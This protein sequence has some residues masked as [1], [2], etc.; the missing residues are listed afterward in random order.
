MIE[1]TMEG[2]AIGTVWMIVLNKLFVFRLEYHKTIIYI[3][4]LNLKIYD[5]ISH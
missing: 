5:W 3:L 2:I 1:Y 4:V